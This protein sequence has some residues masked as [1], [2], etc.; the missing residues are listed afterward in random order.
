MRDETERV[1][2]TNRRLQAEVTE[3]RRR[4][5]AAASRPTAAAASE[6]KSSGGDESR[7]LKE[8]IRSLQRALEEAREENNKRVSETSQFQQMRKLMQNQSTKLRDLRRRLERYEPDAA[9]EDDD[10]F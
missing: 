9:K 7:E 10:D 3:L 2:E 4:L 6:S 8:T 1:E 5:D